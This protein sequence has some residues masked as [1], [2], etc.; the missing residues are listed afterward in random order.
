MWCS[1]RLN[2]VRDRLAQSKRD[3]FP[4]AACD[5]DGCLSGKKQFDSYVEMQ[6]NKLDFDLGQEAVLDHFNQERQQIEQGIQ[7]EATDKANA[8]SA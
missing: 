7:K 3:F 4:C 5:V 6:Q 8:Q 1:K 2:A